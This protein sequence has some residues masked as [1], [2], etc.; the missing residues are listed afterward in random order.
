MLPSI[1]PSKARCFLLLSPIIVC[2]DHGYKVFLIVLA[3]MI[4][5]LVHSVTYYRHSAQCSRD[6]RNT[7]K[8]LTTA[9][10]GRWLPLPCFLFFPSSFIQKKMCWRCLN[11]RVDTFVIRSINW[12]ESYLLFTV[13]F[14]S[15]TRW[16]EIRKFEEPVRGQWMGW[17]NWT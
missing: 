17:S 1:L 9:V 6:S 10:W 16:T 14:P 7:T 13:F 12:L 15:S 8:T 5:Q 3:R 11:S 4:W 2:D